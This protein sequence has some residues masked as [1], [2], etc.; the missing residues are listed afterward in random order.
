MAIMAMR[1]HKFISFMY[2]SDDDQLWSK[3][4]GVFKCFKCFNNWHWNSVIWRKVHLLEQIK[5][6]EWKCRVKQWNTLLTF[7]KVFT[8]TLPFVR[9]YGKIWY[10]QTDRQTSWVTKATNTHSEYGIFIPFPR[11]QWL[12]ENTCILSFTYIACLVY[13]Q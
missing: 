2:C 4:V 10:R 5:D 13:V 8:I 1:Q 7:N 6:S 3:H 9:R 12:R 11:Q